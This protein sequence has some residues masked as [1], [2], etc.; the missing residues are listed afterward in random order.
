MGLIGMLLALAIV[1]WLYGDALKAYLMPPSPPEATTKSG[2]PGA[3]AR[4]VGGIG[5]V[6]ID[7]SSSTGAPQTAI[8]RARG[9]EDTVRRQAEQRA[10]QGDGV[11][12]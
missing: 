2:T 9:V 12:R 8:E 1:A 11:S 7:V 6:D 10:N 5:P 3:A 4:A